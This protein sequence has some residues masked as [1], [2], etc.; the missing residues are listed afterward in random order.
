M[1]RKGMNK[2]LKLGI[3]CV[4]AVVLIIAVIVTNVILKPMEE[5]IS[6]FLSQPI[7]DEEA[8]AVSS[9]SGQKLSER[10]VEEGA[11][12]FKNENDALPLDYSKDKKVNVFGWRSVDWRLGRS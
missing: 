2:F 6:S 4:C 1:K 5:Q 3:H 12:M 7:V 11:V 8:L 10:I 9:A